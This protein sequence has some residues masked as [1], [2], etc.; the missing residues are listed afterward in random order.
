M[1]GLRDITLILN[2]TVALITNRDY[3]LRIV[4]V[5]MRDTKCS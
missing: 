3:M 4:V 5:R 2:A 1:P